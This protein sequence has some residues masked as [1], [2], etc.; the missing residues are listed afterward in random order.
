MKS[1][2]KLLGCGGAAFNLI[3]SFVEN[4]RD[5]EKTNDV[6]FLVANRLTWAK[7]DGTNT[8]RY[9]IRTKCLKCLV[10]ISCNASVAL[11]VSRV[12]IGLRVMIVLTGVT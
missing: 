8:A 1:I 4:L 5:I 10:T 12:T 3:Q 6:S 11:V 9:G 7:L 2:V